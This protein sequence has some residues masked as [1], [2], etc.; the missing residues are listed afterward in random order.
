MKCIQICNSRSVKYKCC[1]SCGTEWHS[2]VY[3]HKYCNRYNKTENSFVYLQ[4]IH[5]T[6][7]HIFYSTQL[8]HNHF[9]I[10]CISCIEWRFTYWL[11]SLHIHNTITYHWAG[12]DFCILLVRPCRVLLL[13]NHFLTCSSLMFPNTARDWTTLWQG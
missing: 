5:T 7:D 13:A 4:I 1:N 11:W 12:M 10:T 2:D 9:L 6:I 8:K 3:S